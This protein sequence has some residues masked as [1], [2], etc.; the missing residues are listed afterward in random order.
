M[1]HVVKSPLY[2]KEGTGTDHSGLKMGL[3]ISLRSICIANIYTD[4]SVMD[5]GLM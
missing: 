1:I 2:F 3:V 4:I 5:S